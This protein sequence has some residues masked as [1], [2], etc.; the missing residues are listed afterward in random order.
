MPGKPASRRL[1]VQGPNTAL[2]APQG[3][4]R[5]RQRNDAGPLIAHTDV[6]ELLLDKFPVEQ[7]GRLS[8]DEF[9]YKDSTQ[10]DITSVYWDE[11]GLE[12]TAF[13]LIAR[14]WPEIC[15]PKIA[16]L[17]IG[18]SATSMFL[19]KRSFIYAFP[20]LLN[21]IHIFPTSPED[22]NTGPASLLMDCFIENDLNLRNVYEDWKLA[23][24]FSFDDD[25]INLV[26][27]ILKGI[28]EPLAE[29]AIESY[30]H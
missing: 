1:I 19:N 20:S 27:A 12:K 23:F 15:W 13:E 11:P 25:T 26:G 28:N 6:T 30:W 2:T 16:G 17:T 4:V 5:Q 10:P 9:I 22:E 7:Y 8:Y 29:D 24:Y 21:F 14:P 3:G 18:G